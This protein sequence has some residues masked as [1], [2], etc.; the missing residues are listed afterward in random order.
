[1]RATSLFLAA[2]VLFV[3]IIAVAAD[4]TPH[5]VY[6]CPMAD[7]PKEFDKPGFCPLDG[8]E[9]TDK[10]LRLHVA[11]LVHEGVEEIDYAG[12]LEVFGWSGAVTFTVAPS[13]AVLHSAFGL[14]VK[15]DYDFEHAPPSDVLLIPG[16]GIGPAQKD[17][18][19]LEWIRERS[20]TSRYVMSV[21]NGAFILARTG[22]LDGLSATT[23]ATAN[24]R[25]AAVAP[26][27]HV[28][29]DRRFV[30]N[31]KFIT[32]AGLSSGIDGALHV[33]ERQYGRV[34]AE[35]IAR[36]IEY[37]WQPDRNWTRASLADLRMPDILPLD[38]SW[39][40]LADHGDTRQWEVRGRLGTS[41]PPED[42]LNDCA[43]RL[44]QQNWTLRATAKGQRTFARTE[45]GTTWIYTIVLASDTS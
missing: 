37:D 10:N 33:V 35:E 25:L 11:V 24:K 30:D 29:R 8:M 44:A 5:A 1:M 23:T 40:K 16:G 15:P 2:F 9:L 38:V 6:V 4:S 20:A 43:K 22:L 42:F 34:K 31:G 36:D 7:H 45:D 17:E 14:Q 32:T 41:M 26:K 12:P 13:T 39:E 18:K 27:I 19:I 28:V 3:P 21:C